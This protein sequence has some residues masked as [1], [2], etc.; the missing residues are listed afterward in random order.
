MH[1]KKYEIINT[2]DQYSSMVYF[3]CRKSSMDLKN[4][5]WVCLV[6]KMN[7]VLMLHHTL[8]WLHGLCT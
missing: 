4:P 5:G 6:S 3:H 7:Y 8:S 1:D 2:L